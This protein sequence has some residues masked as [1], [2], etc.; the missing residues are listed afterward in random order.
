M[1]KRLI[2]GL[3]AVFLTAVAFSQEVSGRIQALYAQAQAQEKSGQVEQ[4]ITSYLEIVKFDPKLA[5][6]QNN[7]G[8]LY[9]QQGRLEEASKALRRACEL[10]P[11]LAPPRALLGFALFQMGD[12]EGARRELKIAVQ[13]NPKD[14]NARLFLARSLV[15]LK[16]LKGALK[17]LEQLQQEDPK[18]TEALFT[19]GNLYSSLAE[20]T[21][22]SIQTVDPSSYLI[23]VL[24]G[25]YS[26]VK[27]VYKDAA[28]HYKRAIERA[29]DVPDLYYR[30]AH[31]LWTLGDAQNAVAQYKKALEMN[32]Y[33]YRAAWEEARAVLADNPEEAVRLATQA[34][35][36]KPDLAEAMTI[37][38]RALLALQKP[39]DAV[40]D[41]K[42]A[43]ALNAA[44]PTSHF[45][46][47]R[48]YRQLGLTQEAQSENAAYE[49]LDQAARAAKE[50]VVVS[51]Q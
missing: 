20:K 40:K 17:I 42:S 14:A 13:L 35:K 5:A 31:A 6:A 1:G 11:K 23:E 39:E 22:G 3:A 46:L 49:R 33:D 25:S 7:L 48:A 43:I 38:G 15:E 8:R 29:P 26:E 32:P 41:L 47:A 9:Y 34:L 51:P 4:S 28:E 19:L 21:I 37:R 18:N 50:Q 36:L 44:D 16:D 12:F 2:A 30:Y 27:Q 24:L 45:Q 10:D